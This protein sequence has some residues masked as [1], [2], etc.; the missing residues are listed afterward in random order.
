[1]R[2]SD[3]ATDY[4]FRAFRKIFKGSG[5]TY[6]FW[7][8]NFGNAFSQVAFSQVIFLIQRK[9]FGSYS[10]HVP[11]LQWN[12][13]NRHAHYTLDVFTKPAA[14]LDYCRPNPGETHWAG[15]VSAK[16]RH[17]GDR[18]IQAFGGLDEWSGN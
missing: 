17:R 12:T 18:D 6:V 9:V 5:V 16:S 4:S 11:G 1:M 10:P 3:F 7:V 2:N 14:I 15:L 8:L 13:C